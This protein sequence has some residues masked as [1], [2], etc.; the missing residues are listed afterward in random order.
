MIKYL[1]T[2]SLFGQYEWWYRGHAAESA[3]VDVSLTFI[4][5]Y[6]F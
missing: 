5:L 3:T 4:N 1:D 2:F 6:Y